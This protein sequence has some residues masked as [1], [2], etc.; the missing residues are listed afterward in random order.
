ML[1]RQKPTQ[2]SE[3]GFR[4]RWTLNPRGQDLSQPQPQQPNNVIS[5]SIVESFPLV[6]Y[7]KPTHCAE[8]EQGTGTET[9]T[10]STRP[11]HNVLSSVSFSWSRRKPN[12]EK[13][14]S[15]DKMS[16]SPLIL[17]LMLFRLIAPS[18]LRPLPHRMKSACFL[19]DKSIIICMY[20]H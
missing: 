15:Q 11:Q 10:P 14:P 6:R 3:H 5:S 20:I 16:K 1:P 12:S 17:P 13:P 19:A 9:N 7:D 2:A 8:I 18:A 4:E